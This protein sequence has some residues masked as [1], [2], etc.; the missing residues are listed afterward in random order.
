MNNIVVYA[1]DIGSIKKKRFGWCRAEIFQDKRYWQCETDKNKYADI[2]AFVKSIVDDLKNKKKVAIGFECPLFVPIAD[3]A[4]DLTK[5]RDGENNRP[6]SAGAGCA[7]L[8]TGL[9]ECVYI[10]KKIREENVDVK[11]SFRW[12][13]FRKNKSNLFIWEA[14]V[15]SLSKEKTHANDAKK[16]VE[17]FLALAKSDKVEEGNSVKENV[18]SL[19]GAGLLRA[20]LTTNLELI[21]ERCIVIK[22][23]KELLE[24]LHDHAIVADRRDEPTIT[25][26][27]NSIKD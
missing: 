17:T 22:S 15:T 23:N 6:W 25:F 4:E 19:V 2:D 24:D 1:A 10:F 11:P 9:T 26:L 21:A 16:A 20:G 14:F 5:A 7:V 12:E 27:G 3:K 13:E 8:A 18:Y